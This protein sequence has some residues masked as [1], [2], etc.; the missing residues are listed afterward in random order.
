MRSSGHAIAHHPARLALGAGCTAH[1]SS[2]YATMHVAPPAPPHACRRRSCALPDAVWVEG[3]SRRAWRKLR[4]GRRLLDCPRAGYV[5]VQPRWERRGSGYVY[6]E[7]GWAL[8]HPSPCAW[9]RPSR[10][11][12]PSS[13]HIGA[14]SVSATHHG[15]H[16]AA[17][18]HDAGSSAW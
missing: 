9:L 7:P 18:P 15:L 8:R 17:T 16:R 12:A 13:A 1:A 4:L 3:H 5:Y 6:V 14:P 10:R 11:T 2:G